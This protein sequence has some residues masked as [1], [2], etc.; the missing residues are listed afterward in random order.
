MG[1]DNLWISEMN[2]SSA[3][4]DRRAEFGIRK[5]PVLP[6][7]R[8]RVIWQRTQIRCIHICTAD[9]RAPTEGV[10]PLTSGLHCF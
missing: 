8:S 5:V 3:V 10:T 7:T 9:S 6:V 1:A 4:R 2:T